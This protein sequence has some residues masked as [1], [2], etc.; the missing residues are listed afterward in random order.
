MVGDEE[1]QAWDWQ[2]CVGSQER[3]GEEEMM[4]R[5]C[6]METQLLTQM[7]TV[8]HSLSLSLLCSALPW[9]FISDNLIFY[10]MKKYLII[11]ISCYLV[12]TAALINVTTAAQRCSARGFD[13]NYW[14]WTENRG[15]T[16]YPELRTVGTISERYRI[17]FKFDSD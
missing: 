4:E 7:S 2:L 1:K 8:S 11:I 10:W 14:S 5:S 17:C 15:L 6:I 9:H 16:F 3:R 13:I 12:N